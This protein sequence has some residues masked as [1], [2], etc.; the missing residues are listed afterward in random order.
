MSR[1]GVVHAAVVDHL[2]ALKRTLLD[3][4]QA[5]TAGQR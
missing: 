5:P 2:S 3:A 1:H 4:E